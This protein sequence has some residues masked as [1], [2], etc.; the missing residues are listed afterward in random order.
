MERYKKNSEERRMIENGKSYWDN[1]YWDKN[2]AEI[3]VY[4]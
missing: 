1:E 3:Y 4:V 2:L